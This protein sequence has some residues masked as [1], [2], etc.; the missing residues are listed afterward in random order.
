MFQDA[1]DVQRTLAF[2]RQKLNCKWLLLGLVC[3][4]LGIGLLWAKSPRATAEDI[5][6]CTLAIALGGFIAGY[7]LFRMA[8]PGKPLVVLSRSGIRM[9]IE[10]VKHFDIPWHE[11]RGVDT[12]DI[13][14]NLGRHSVTFEGVTVVLV[15]RAFY[16][17][18]IHIASWLLRGP[19]W[20]ANFIPKDDL[21]QVALHHEAL[22]VEASDLRTAVEMRWQAFRDASRPSVP[23][24]SEL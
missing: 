18:R 10:W 20:D 9:Q 22:P 5:L 2:G 16:Q 3:L 17:R 12:I 7:A 24:V 21:V 13:H 6:M 19:G 8:V 14:A 11:V 15:S 23:Q 4:A 1:I